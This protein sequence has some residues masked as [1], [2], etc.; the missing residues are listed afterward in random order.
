[1]FQLLD[2]SL[3]Q[4]RLKDTI[5]FFNNNPIYISDVFQDAD[6]FFIAS[7]P[8]NNLFYIGDCGTR[9]QVDYSD[10]NIG[11]ASFNNNIYWVFRNSVRKW[12]VGLNHGNSFIRR[13]GKN[14]RSMALTRE[15]L[16]GFLPDFF[17]MLNNDYPINLKNNQRIL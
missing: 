3:T 16:K 12:K 9:A 15:T 8:S 2:L 7:A 17:Q 6:K 10:M 1:M 11:M 4:T 13:V 5:V 14:G